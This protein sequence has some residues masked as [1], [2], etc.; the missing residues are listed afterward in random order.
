MNLKFVEVS[1]S[2]AVATV[3]LNR[4]DKH[5]AL[6]TQM[7]LELIACGEQLRS[8]RDI[9]AVILTG[10]GQSFCAGMDL[11]DIMTGGLLKRVMAFLPLWKPTMNRYQKVS[12]V[13]RSLS[14][15]VI[16]AIHGNCFG[17]GLQV[18]LGADIRIA[19]PGSQLSI[20]ESNWGLVPDMGGTVVLRELLSK[21]VA[22]ELT[23]SGRTIEAEQAKALCLVTHIADDPLEAAHQL[24]REF[25]TQSPDALAAGKKLLLGAWS[26]SEYS[27]L[28]QERLWQRRVIGKRN[29][30]IAVARRL[31]SSQQSYE[32]RTR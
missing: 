1:Y 20:M 17:A 29:Q 23:F 2:G 10:N 24:C 11:K 31:Q 4:P 3:H 26:G 16:A 8:N 30:N 5:N 6:N 14:V 27:A 32:R 28:R 18:A 7:L 22:M 25:E 19:A 9:R 12:L 13:W 15:P 21:D